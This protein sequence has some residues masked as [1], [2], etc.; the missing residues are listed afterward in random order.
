MVDSKEDNAAIDAILL[1]AMQ[2]RPGWDC[3]DRIVAAPLAQCGGCCLEDAIN[4]AMPGN[5]LELCP[6]Q[7]LERAA[8]HCELME[9][10]DLSPDRD[11]DKSYLRRYSDDSVGLFTSGDSEAWMSATEAQ[12]DLFQRVSA[13]DWASCGYEAFFN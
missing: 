2:S 5:P 4:E 1:C 3:A 10:L 13:D 7:L 11:T 8:A 12:I 6:Q 9:E